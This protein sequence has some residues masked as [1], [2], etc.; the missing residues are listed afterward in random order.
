MAAGSCGFET[1]FAKN[2]PHLLEK[3]F[4]SLDYESFKTCREVNCTWHKLLTSD[5]Y[6]KKAKSVFQEGILEDEKKLW[7]AS[8]KGNVAEALRILDIAIGL[9]DINCMVV[10][11]DGE[12]Y[13]S[14][15]LWQ[16]GPWGKKDMVQLLLERGAD[17]NKADTR[18]RTPLHQ[19]AYIGYKDIVLLLLDAGAQPNKVGRLWHASKV[20]NIEEVTRL[21]DSG[22]LDVNHVFKWDETTAL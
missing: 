20:G 11:G 21:L 12:A 6:L 5:S 2:V 18:G 3:I 14:T 1:L 4:F 10:Y 22:M 7:L 8:K 9:V 19:T 17:P 13:G 16:A 15:P